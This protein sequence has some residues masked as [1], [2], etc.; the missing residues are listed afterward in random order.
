VVRAAR[1]QYQFRMHALAGAVDIRLTFFDE[2]VAVIRVQTGMLTEAARD[3]T[4]YCVHEPGSAGFGRLYLRAIRGALLWPREVPPEGNDQCPLI[5]Y[6]L[7]DEPQ[8][9]LEDSLN[10]PPYHDHFDMITVTGCFALDLLYLRDEEMQ[11]RAKHLVTVLDKQ[12]LTRLDEMIAPVLPENIDGLLKL[13]PRSGRL[14]RRTP[15]PSEAITP[16]NVHFWEPPFGDDLEPLPMRVVYMHDG[17]NLFDPRTSYLGVDWGVGRTMSRLVTEKK[18]PPTMVVGIWNTAAR[19]QEY[20]PQQPV[21][22]LSD[23]DLVARLNETYGTSI[24]D[25]YLSFVVD[26]LKPHVDQSFP[27]LTG[28]KDTFVMGSSMGG[29]ISL[30]A[31]CRYPDVFGG[32]ACLSTHYP[33]DLDFFLEWLDTHLPEGRRLYFDYGTTGGDERIEERQDRVNEVLHGKG[34]RE[35]ENLMVRRFEGADHSEWAW[36]SRLHLPFQFLLTA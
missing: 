3:Y 31:L 5:E 21:A 16:R 4:L 27:V 1:A 23:T 24:S 2:D 12:K 17:Q 25:A 7:L 35:G 30:Y 33:E 8:R 19:L 10:R 13:A 32:A 26:E 6:I 14:T 28:V 29:L 11:A 22:G 34:Y 36:R 15:F 18:V 9:F 20:F